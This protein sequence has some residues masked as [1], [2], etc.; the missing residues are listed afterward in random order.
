MA[1][2]IYEI[3]PSAADT[4]SHC[5]GSIKLQQLYPE[6]EGPEAK[7]GT[8]AHFVWSTFLLKGF[9]PEVTTLA[10]NAVPVTEEMIDHGKHFVSVVREHGLPLTVEQVIGNAAIHKKSGGTPD[11]WCVDHANRI[12]YIYD[13]KF[14]H[15]YVEVYLN[16]QMI[17]Y[18]AEILKSLGGEWRIEFC[19]VQPRCFQSPEP[20]RRWGCASKD[21]DST[22]NILRNA[23][24]Y[25]QIQDPPTKA[26]LYCDECSARHG[27]QTVQAA[28]EH[29]FMITGRSVPF[30][31][32]PTALGQ[33]LKRLTWAAKILDARITGLEQQA[34]ALMKKGA[35]VPNYSLEQKAGRLTWRDG[36]ANQVIGLGALYGKNLAQAPAPKTPT[37]CI[38]EGIDPTVIN[39]YAFRPMGEFKL[40]RIDTTQTRKIFGGN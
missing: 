5:Y 38:A 8:A 27:C 16:R 14:G 11:V 25:S 40:T 34:I 12:I 35:R 18:A 26:G 19:V 36:V 13:Y 6:E 32:S 9:W 7:E 33:D 3:R 28:A 15:R 30:E 22:I 4:W 17:C 1:A 10:D 31:L 29:V 23:A 21:L 37:Q 2:S 20:V 39:D 24:D